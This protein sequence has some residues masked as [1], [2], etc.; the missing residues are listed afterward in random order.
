MNKLII[1]IGG[2]GSGKSTFA[3]KLGGKTVSSDSVRK[4]LYGNESVIFN[5][6]I[7]EMLINEKGISPCS[8]SSEELKQL[9]HE[10][11]EDYVFVVARRKCCDLLKDGY[12]VVYDSTN[13]KKKYRSQLLL[14]AEG[15]YDECEAFV[16][17][18]PLETAIL[19]NA[20]RK[21]NEPESIVRE[22]CS[23]LEFPEYSEGYDRIFS[24]DSN[25][26]ISLVPKC[27]DSV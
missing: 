3:K 20:S 5:E 2:V 11:C 27:G 9:K 6:E 8:M 24:V 23:M 19:R 22:I 16:M 26:D 15:L 4:A 14:E 18:V 1:I 10:L 12:D 7:S 17:D 21:R 25:S 13:F